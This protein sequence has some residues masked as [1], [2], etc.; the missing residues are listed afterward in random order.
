MFYKKC[1]ILFFVFNAV[2][3]GVYVCASEFIYIDSF[4]LVNLYYLL[5][6]TVALNYLILNTKNG[7]KYRNWE[8]E[9][10]SPETSR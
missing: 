10:L 1:K 7:A 8:R 6:L 9:P 2:L 4:K 3:I 5:L